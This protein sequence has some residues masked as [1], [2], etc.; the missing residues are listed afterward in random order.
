MNSIRVFLVVVILAAITLFSFIAALR[1]Y[2]S[3]MQEAE[4]LFD[5]QL[6]DTARLIANIHTESTAGNINHDSGIAF[7]VWQDDQL[8]ASSSNAPQKPIGEQEAGFGYSNFDGLRWRTV[9]YYDP[10][11]R[12][13]V[14]AAERTDLRYTLAENVILKSI[15]PILIGLPIIGLLIWLIVSQGLRPLRKLANLLGSKQPED[16]SPLMIDSPRR[17]L[18]K[19]I[20]SS[21]GLLQ[22]LETSLQRERQ[23]ASDAAHELRTPIST[24]K[25]Q[26]YNLQQ[27]L[28]GGT[29]LDELNATTER[30]A[31]I[32]EQI[33]ALYRSSPDQY[34]A[35]LVPIDLAALAQE[36]MA[37]EYASF[38]RK[39]QSL[40]FFGEKNLI[41]GDRFALR[42]LLQNLLANANKY[43]PAGGSIEVRLSHRLVQNPQGSST[44]MT[45]AKQQVILSVEDSGPG[46]PAE[47][48]AAVFERFYRVGGDRHPSDETGCGLGLAIV[49]RIVELH[50]AQISVRDSERLHGAAFEITFPGLSAESQKFESKSGVNPL[51]TSRTG[52]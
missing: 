32:V 27:S 30:L 19:I 9:A 5:K 18:A 23:F 25:V 51:Q 3:S 1:G 49:K 11:S 41:L 26:L 16:L 42:T 7:Q 24:L 4:R 37:E 13:W 44:R 29:A 12:Y 39:Q 45:E 36:V 43:T 14:L 22:R 15:F 33:L 31:H 34:N 46:I 48:R 38:D 28:Q 40:E 21:N 47:Q 6:L 2:Q 20:D 35:A 50:H 17:E 8:R 52:P 10:I